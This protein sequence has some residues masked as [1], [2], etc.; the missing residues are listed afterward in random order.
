MN[1]E[2]IPDKKTTQMNPKAATIVPMR[3]QAY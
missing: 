2:T 3:L 1:S